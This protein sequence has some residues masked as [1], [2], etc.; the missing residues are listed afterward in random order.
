MHLALNRVQT[1]SSQLIPAH[2]GRE[3]MYTVRLLQGH[4]SLGTPQEV[5]HPTP[6]NTSWTRSGWSRRAMKLVLSLPF[7]TAL[8]HNVR[9]TPNSRN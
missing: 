2:P 8:I 4:G 7:P 6:Q 9:A 3:V 1:G 5:E